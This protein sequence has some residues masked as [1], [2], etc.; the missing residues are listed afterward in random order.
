MGKGKVEIEKR[1]KY[2]N[3][4]GEERMRIMM[5][6]CRDDDDDGLRDV[7]VC[8]R[9]VRECDCNFRSVMLREERIGGSR[10]V[11]FGCRSF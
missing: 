8:V 9:C 2:A 7:C 5:N 10:S 6:A 11:C 4:F 3:N 1:D